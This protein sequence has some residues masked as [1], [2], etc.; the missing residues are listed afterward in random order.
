MRR[1]TLNKKSLI[2]IFFVALFTILSFGFDQMVIRTEDKIRNLNIE[3]QNI[4]NSLSKHETISETLDSISIG[5]GLNFTP[6][7][8]RRNLLIKS[9][10]LSGVK[11]YDFLNRKSAEINAQDL[12]RMMIKEIIEVTDMTIEIRS[13][14]FQLYTIN[15]EVF[16]KTGIDKYPSL[17]N[18][19]KVNMDPF[20][21]D[22]DK[23]YNKNIL[24]YTKL[25]GFNHHWEDKS[26]SEV[27][28]YRV[29]A[30]KNFGLREWYDVYKYKM[31][32]FKK[33]EKDT[34]ILDELSELFVLKSDELLKKLSE[35]ITELKFSNIKKN[36][37][38]LTSI[39]FQ[40]VSLLFLLLL[41]RSFIVK[42]S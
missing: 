22:R 28:E 42:F 33:I 19:F 21:K 12:G 26:Y 3:Y 29:K 39:F 32:L 2:L 30:I 25:L 5:V 20:K 11:S 41:F 38:I 9:Y 31:L 6:I 27:Q 36:F 14:Y 4:N 7:T 34:E 37:Y 18:L 17:P 8:L 1:G 35:K 40:I 10:I 15:K 13:Q 16:D 23:F 24:I